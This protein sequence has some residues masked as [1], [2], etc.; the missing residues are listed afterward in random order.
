MSSCSERRCY[1]TFIS[2]CPEG[3]EDAYQC[4]LKPRNPCPTDPVRIPSSVDSLHPKSPLRGGSTC[5]T[6]YRNSDFC[7]YNISMNCT[8]G[9]E[10]ASVEM[11][12]EP[13]TDNNECLDY[14]QFDYGDAGVSEKF[15]GQQNLKLRK[16]DINQFIMVFWT[17]SHSFHKGFELS[18]TCL[19]SDGSGSDTGV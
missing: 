19:D 15:C 7:V 10:I 8:D 5:G 9:V 14:I 13:P 16:P 4:S 2:R 12:L 11:K 18:V 17:N 1:K 6:R 3:S